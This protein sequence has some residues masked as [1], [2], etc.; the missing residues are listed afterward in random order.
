MHWINR[1][2]SIGASLICTVHSAQAHTRRY[3]HIKM[4]IVIIHW[5][6]LLHGWAVDI[7]ACKHFDISLLFRFLFSFIHP[8][9]SLIQPSR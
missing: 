6:W 8:I 9:D 1:C 2:V 3:F 7:A 5:K 4:F